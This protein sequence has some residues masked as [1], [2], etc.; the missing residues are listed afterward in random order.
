[1]R[2]WGE[3]EI[4]GGRGGVTAHSVLTGIHRFLRDM[5]DIYVQT[6]SILM[7]CGIPLGV[8]LTFLAER[9]A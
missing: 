8:D 6:P 4:F 5:H 3:N 2:G 1:M 9:V 7:L